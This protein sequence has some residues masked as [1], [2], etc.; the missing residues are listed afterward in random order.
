MR[1]GGQSVSGPA[2]L[3]LCFLLTSY[4]YWG[5]CPPS[6]RS[7]ST[8]AYARCPG[9]LRSHRSVPL[10][11]LAGRGQSRRRR[12]D[13]FRSPAPQERPR[14]L[15]VGRRRIPGSEP[16]AMLYA[17]HQF[18]VWV[19]QLGDG[20]ALL[21]GEVRNRRGQ[22]WDLHLKGGGPTVSPAAATGGRCCAV[23]DPRVPRAVKRCTAWD[24]HHPGAGHRRQREQVQR[25]TTERRRPCCDWRRRH[26]RFGTFEILPPGGA[27]TWCGRSPTTSSPTTPLPRGRYAG[28]A[29][30][31]DR[32]HRAAD[33]LVAGGRVHAR[34]DE[35]RQHVGAR[36]D[37]RLR[38]LRLRR[39]VRPGLHREPLR[40]R[41]PLR[42]RPAARRRALEPDP[43]RRGAALARVPG[44]RRRR[45]SAPIGQP[46]ST[47]SGFGCGP[48]WARR[49]TARGCG[50]GPATSSRM[51]RSSRWTTPASSG[52]WADS[53][54]G[55]GLPRGAPRRSGG[56][57]RPRRAGWRL[58]GP[59]RVE[60]S[61]DGERQARM[62]RVNPVYVLR[63]WLA[64]RAIRQAVEER[65]RR[66]R[67]A[68]GAAQVPLLR[69]ARDARSTPR[70]RRSGRGISRSTARPSALSAAA[71]I[72]QSPPSSL[73]LDRTLFVTKRM[74]AGRSASRRMYHR[75]Q[76]ASVADQRLHRRPSDATS[77][78]WAAL[79]M[80]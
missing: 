50:T 35:H 34:G 80:P 38:P 33:R 39:G 1:I 8:T 79:R 46:S 18:G 27:P 3:T 16:V 63:T 72:T 12:A 61:K 67:T 53:R 37:P 25:E 66:D 10:A 69:A 64:E 59:S 73:H 49:V 15:S 42:L 32:P 14:P 76:A 30:R 26:V 58:P 21:L 48:S 65:D 19:P 41:G 52:P 31:G 51:L 23:V 78:R 74:L 60:R 9:L 22:K 28:L 11:S 4:L 40:P 20:R 7:F 2:H 54:P 36:A 62:A 44:A 43:V 70:A 5:P 55:W 17:G 13:R 6:P 29:P 71:H 56:R 57:S 68:P 47:I 24:P 77:A 45:R 75:N